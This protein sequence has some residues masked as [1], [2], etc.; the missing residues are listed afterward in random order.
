MNFVKKISLISLLMGTLVS[1]LV[2]NLQY[3]Y[4][5]NTQNWQAPTAETIYP[6]SK[7]EAL[8][9]VARI[10]ENFDNTSSLK[11]FNILW[12][13]ASAPA[14]THD[15]SL[16]GK[17]KKNN[18]KIS[19]PTVALFN[20]ETESFL[21]CLTKSAP[22]T[23]IWLRANGSTKIITK[24]YNAMEELVHTVA[25]R[26]SPQQFLNLCRLYPTLTALPLNPEPTT[27]RRLKK[28]GIA[29]TIGLPLLAL[30]ALLVFGTRQKMRIAQEKVPLL[31]TTT[32]SNDDTANIISLLLGAT[33]L[34]TVPG[35]VL[36]ATGI[37]YAKHEKSSLNALL[38]RVRI[39]NNTG[40]TVLLDNYNIAATE[41]ITCP[42]PNAFGEEKERAAEKSV[43][44]LSLLQKENAPITFPA[45]IDGHDG[46][47]GPRHVQ[48]FVLSK[49]IALFN[50]ETN[51][52]IGLLVQNKKAS[53]YL[54]RPK[55]REIVST[56]ITSDD[57]IN[58]CAAY[59]LMKG[60]PFNT[61]KKLNER[62]LAT[63]IAI[64]LSSG[65][66]IMPQTS[67]WNS[68]DS[69][70]IAIARATANAQ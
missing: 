50:K 57:L 19:G 68:T 31:P 12:D 38:A 45:V 42:A 7:E 44:I 65:G 4:L 69:F 30:I 52:Y 11:D 37:E 15:A 61:E 40:F 49:A 64:G 70:D 10:E 6:I 63:K 35:P 17:A 33:A 1:N 46:R 53:H 67:I 41:E 28:A 32:K 48:Q 43:K 8:L 25:T 13:R 24:H 9:T 3:L 18:P 47:N 2:A 14:T 60:R 23:Y 62:A 66:L 27:H 59:P 56:A 34:V 29:L 36:L 58:L 22:D 5:E 51:R 20:K 55:N 21:G 54:I 39:K 16:K 26:L